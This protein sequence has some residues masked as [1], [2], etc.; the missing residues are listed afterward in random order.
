MFCL[1]HGPFPVSWEGPEERTHGPYLQKNTASCLPVLAVLGDKGSAW[2]GQP[3]LWG[4]ERL[5]CGGGKACQASQAECPRE[6]Q[7]APQ[8]GDRARPEPQLDVGVKG[9]LMFRVLLFP[10]HDLMVM[11]WHDPGL[12]GT[13][14]SQVSPRSASRVMHSIPL[15]VQA[16]Q[17]SWRLP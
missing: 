2:E 1:P 9:S 16:T 7:R 5:E 10:P 11:P 3:G 17:L 13:L 12:G 4:S 15:S 14:Q 8:D 6:G